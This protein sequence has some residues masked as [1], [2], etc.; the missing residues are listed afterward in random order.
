MKLFRG[1][2][3]CHVLLSNCSMKITHTR[4]ELSKCGK[5]FILDEFRLGYIVLYIL[6]TFLK[7]EI[8]LK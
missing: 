2:G 7:F 5:I 6:E 8:I 4:E 1:Q 3:A